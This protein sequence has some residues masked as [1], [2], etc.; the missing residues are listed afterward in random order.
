M[1]LYYVC[2]LHYLCVQTQITLHL[3]GLTNKYDFGLLQQTITAYLKA[4]L[5]VANVCVI[6]NVANFYQLKELCASCTS[7]IDMNATEVLKS[8]GFL[9]LSQ[10]A[11]SDLVTRDSFYAPELDIYHGLI[12][13]MEHNPDKRE[14][15]NEL[16]KG[17]RLQLIPLGDLLHEVRTSGNFRPDDILDAISLVEHRTSVDLGHRGLL[18]MSYLITICVH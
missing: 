2:I 18:S 12:K 13:W 5:T 3:L 14:G 9:S 7:F 8:E 15:S 4:T 17:I 11:L 16:L 1:Y 10:S 6:Y